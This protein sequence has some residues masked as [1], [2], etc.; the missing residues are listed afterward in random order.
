MDSEQAQ[1]KDDES[2]ARKKKLFKTMSKDGG[3]L[4]LTKE[5]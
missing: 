4:M 1:K 5:E 2:R 3:G